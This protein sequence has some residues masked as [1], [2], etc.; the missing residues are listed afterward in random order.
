MKCFFENLEPALIAGRTVNREVHFTSL[1]FTVNRARTSLV[2]TEDTP[3]FLVQDL[4]AI[5]N[6]YNTF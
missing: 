2:C 3:H 6:T 4:L 5:C 1:H